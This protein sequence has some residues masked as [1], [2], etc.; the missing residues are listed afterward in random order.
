MTAYRL[1]FA[2]AILAFSA[3]AEVVVIEEII[4]KVNGDVITRSEYDRVM[5]EIRSEIAR[6]N[7]PEEQQ[8]QA[9]KQREGN[10]IRDLV[11]ERLLVQRGKDLSINVE[12]QVLKQRDE[13][14][15]QYKIA[16]MEEFENWVLEKT[17]QPM[18]DLMAQMRDSMLAQAVLGQEVQSKIFVPNADVE[19]YFHEHAD[20]FVRSDG[21]RLS[22]ILISTQGKPPEQ[23]PEIK[24]KAEEIL[25]RVKKGEPFAELARR[26]SE[27]QSAENGGDI[28][29]FRRNTLMKEIE[30][31]VFNA[32]RGYI[33]DL[34]EVANGYLILKV[35]ERYREGQAEL[36]EVEN[37]I[38]NKLMM[39]KVNPAIREYLTKLRDDAYI[40]LRPG[41]VDIAA[42]PGKDTSWSDPAKLAPVTTTKEEVLNKKKKR[43]LLWLIPL[44]GGGDKDSENKDKESQMPGGAA[45]PAES[46]AA[47]PA[48]A[49]AP[50][51]PRAGGPQTP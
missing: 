30:D 33:T 26:H 23:M 24:K 22:E 8:Q 27:S 38:R 15:R 42:A 32:Q 41:Y 14:M 25:A 35:D 16:T 13:I 21:V 7:L 29:I 50:G 40:E 48:E 37:E 4:A 47:A 10:I 5:N 9:L 2:L 3:R 44:P 34:I 1:L 39:P 43:R 11:D 18:E 6:Q 28:G 12:P 49:R 46:A 51:E 36:E 19:K 17:G 31:Q 20:E 45:T